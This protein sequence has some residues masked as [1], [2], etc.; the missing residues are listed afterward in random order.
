LFSG[1]VA[2]FPLAPGRFPC[3]CSRASPPHRQ[4]SG[5][6]RA[7]TIGGR[8]CCLMGEG[9]RRGDRKADRST[10]DAIR[11]RVWLHST[12]HHS[13]ASVR[14]DRHDGALIH[15][16]RPRLPACVRQCQTAFARHYKRAEWSR[17]LRKSALGT[18]A[19]TVGRAC[20]GLVLLMSHKP[21]ALPDIAPRGCPGNTTGTRFQGPR[22]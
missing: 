17:E 3:R 9:S 8:R 5:E 18:E 16:F 2:M 11:L 14:A 22:R 4:P 15:E 6:V 20:D 10:S 1:R 19:Q 7:P 13:H 12:R 21:I